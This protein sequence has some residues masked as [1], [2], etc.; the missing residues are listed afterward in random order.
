MLK[1]IYA[2]AKCSN[3]DKKRNI[4]TFDSISKILFRQTMMSL[5]LREEK[6]F[7]LTATLQ[8]DGEKKRRTQKGLKMKLCLCTLHN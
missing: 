1:F 8:R 3:S 7:L 4:K 6:T 5:R 2:G